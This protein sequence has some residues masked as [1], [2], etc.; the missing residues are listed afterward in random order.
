MITNLSKKITDINVSKDDENFLRNFLKDF[1]HK[2]IETND[3]NDFEKITSEW[4][5]NNIESNNKNFNKILELMEIHKESKFWFTSLIG[6]YLLSL[7]YYKD[8]ILFQNELINLQK[9][10]ENGDS[11]A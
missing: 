1:Y 8:I 6:K 10:A 5:R 4:I 3:F 7:F 9:L 2:I 11:K